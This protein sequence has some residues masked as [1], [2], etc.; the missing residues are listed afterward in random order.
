[1]T[2]RIDVTTA[3]DWRERA[4]QASLWGYHRGTYSELL[5]RVDA[6]EARYE[7]AGAALL[8]LVAQLAFMR[9]VD[10]PETMDKARAVLLG[11]LSHAEALLR[12]YLDNHCQ[13]A[14]SDGMSALCECKLCV[15]TRVAVRRETP[16]P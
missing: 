9:G 8:D 14:D 11:R 10:I 5:R 4:E 15:E 3:I 16:G 6:A 7:Q 2:Q 13:L 12:R 1:M